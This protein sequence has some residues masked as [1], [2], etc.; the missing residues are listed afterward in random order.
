MIRS[1]LSVLAGWAAV[2]VLVVLTDVV[3]GRLHP[4]GFLKGR[5]SPDR[6][7]AFSLA[8][9]APCSILGGW[10]AAQLARAR[11]CRQAAYLILRGEGTGMLYTV[12][13]WGRIQAWCQIGLLAAWPIAVLDCR[14]E[15]GAKWLTATGSGTMRYT[16]RDVAQSAGCGR[17]MDC[18]P[19]SGVSG[20]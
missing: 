14:G 12:M 15:A 8:A 17:L 10:I 6:L 2:G 5:I 11:P 7:S 18:H 4:A 1:I 3:L 19:A 9:A 13:S 16:R 20:R